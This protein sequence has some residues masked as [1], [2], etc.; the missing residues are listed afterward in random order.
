MDIVLITSTIASLFLVIGVAEPLA[1]RLRLPYSVILALLGVLIGA[2]AA[3]FLQTELT[4]ALNPVS[5]AILGLPI[6]SNVFLYVFLPTLLFQATLGMNLRRMLDDWAPIILLAVVAVVAATL[7]VGY[8]LSW[9][10]VLPLTSCLLIGAIVSTTDPSAVVGI[11]RSIS[12][13]RRLARIIEGESLLNDAAAIALFGL[14][15][16]FVMLG[17]PDPRL[18]DALARFPMLIAGGAATGWIA[19][20]LALRVMSAFSRYELAQMSISVALPYLAYIIAEQ[21]IGASGV[22]AVVTA[23]LTLNLAAP[24]RLPPQAWANLR[25]VWDLLAH[26]SGALIFI[27]AA[28]LIPRLL[29]GV[30]L[31][32]IGLVAVV[33]VA[34]AAARAT[35]LFVLL[36]LLT[37]LRASPAV[38]PRYRVAILWGGLRG[39]VTL[40][41]ALAVTESALV[42]PETKRV[43]G[44]LATGFTLFTLI[45]QGAT[46]RPVIG[47]LGL[48]RLSPI[49]EALSRQ[50]V[51]VALQTVREDVARITGNYELSHDIVRSEAKR[52]GE[53][54]DGAVKAAEASTSILDRDR[55]TLGLIALAGAEREA[56]LA[57][58][59]ARTISAR[60]ADQ[61]L[62]DADRLIEGARSGGRSGYQR[63]ARRSLA[64]GRAMRVAAVLHNRLRL[65]R[66]TCCRRC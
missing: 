46:L 50:V 45:V 25:E 65:S 64:Y 35:I 58:M 52:F 63:A 34:A 10:G 16:G 19:A 33:I 42:P 26:W 43:V 7:A 59:L 36:P 13:P 14:F 54:L 29:E 31:A 12:A 41:L 2:A 55:V 49:D 3:F 24:G 51:A 40:A 9:T 23:G 66:P 32:D 61:I 8:A 56:I 21:S 30:D 5:E 44:I 39:A 22:I 38:E 18:D 60:M 4:D 1:A 53:R 6:R 57:R 28:L 11:F 27:L 17:V 48:D 62:S 37:L 20:R 15:M 47:W